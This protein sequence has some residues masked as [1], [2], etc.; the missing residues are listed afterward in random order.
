MQARLVQLQE[1]VAV[2][3]GRL[4]EEVAARSGDLLSQATA[5]READ[6]TM[7]VQAGRADTTKPAYGQRL[8]WAPSSSASVMS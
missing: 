7:Q 8:A 1:G 6:D 4:R 5:L 3:N 2:L